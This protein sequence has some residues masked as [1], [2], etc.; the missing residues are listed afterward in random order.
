M[1]CIVNKVIPA[2]AGIQALLP[3]VIEQLQNLLSEYTC[4]NIPWIVCA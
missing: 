3:D 1:L 2:N 4:P